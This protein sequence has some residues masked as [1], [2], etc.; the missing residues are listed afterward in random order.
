MEKMLLVYPV[1]AMFILTCL[2]MVKMRLVSMKLVK[3]KKISFRYFKLYN[4]EVPEELEQARQHYKN[5]F[6]TPILFYI[7]IAIIYSSGQVSVYDLVF[8]W[9][10][11][12][13]KYI[14][15]YIRFTS[16][17]VPYRANFFILSLLMILCGWINFLFI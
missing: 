11:V 12:L 10:Y 7:L 5:L 8:A 4:E 17:Y 2:V 6:E 16:N 1:F 15:S 14:H 9:L 13:F 3:Q